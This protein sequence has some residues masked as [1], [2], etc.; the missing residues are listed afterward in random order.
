MNVSQRFS[1]PMALGELLGGV[2]AGMFIRRISIGL[3]L[4]G[5]GHCRALILT[6]GLPLLSPTSGLCWLG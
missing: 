3:G 2:V 5:R 1:R 4:A 6:S